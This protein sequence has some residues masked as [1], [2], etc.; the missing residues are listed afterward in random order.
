VAS[1]L[2]ADRELQKDLVQEMLLHLVR[3]ETDLPGQTVSWYIASC[4]FHARNYLQRGRSI[5]SMKRGGNLVPLGADRDG[6]NAAFDGCLD[7]TDPVDLHA[8]LVMRDVVNLLN[9]RLTDVQQKVLFFLMH[10]LGA[11]EIG[12]ELSLSHPTVIRHRKKIRRVT[13]HLLAD[14]GCNGARNAGSSFEVRSC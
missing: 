8:E 10:G 13:S 11:R 4:K 3:L 7:P 12:R 6:A 1:H 2:T 14:S 5:D 9:V